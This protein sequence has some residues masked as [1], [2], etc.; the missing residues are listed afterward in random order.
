[1]AA[2]TCAAPPLHATPLQVCLISGAS[3]CKSD[4][5]LKLF[6]D[7][8]ESGFNAECTLLQTPDLNALPGLE[9]LDACDVALFF[10]QGI[11][12]DGEALGRVKRYCAAGKPI[13]GVRTA[14]RGFDKWPAFD[15]E[16]L[17]GHYDGHFEE[18]P[19]VEVSFK[20]PA[21]KHPIMEGVE[22]FRSR[23]SLYRTAPLAK[24]AQCLL[25]GHI[26][27]EHAPQPLAWT[28]ED[29]GCRVFYTSLG[30]VDDF[31][32]ASFK[33][34]IANA[35]FWTAKR[36]IERK[37]LPEIPPRPKNEGT[38][39][40]NARMRVEP[41]HG[42]GAWEEKTAE[43]ELPVGATAIVVCD[44]WDDYW[45]SFSRERVDKMAPA[46][47]ILIAAARKAGMPII[48]APSETLGFY[49]ETIPRR[50]AQAAP[51][52]RPPKPRQIEEP[53]LPVDDSD[54]GC[55]IRADKAYMAWT[56]EHAAVTIDDTDFVSDDGREIYNVLQ[57][58]GVKNLI[59]LG[60]H[61]NTCVL[62]RSFGIR[63]MTR[64]GVHCFL[65]R[66]LTDAMYNPARPPKVDHDKGSELVVEHI[67]KYWC[68]SILSEDL[69]KGLPKP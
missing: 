26:P 52:V 7:Y 3:E 23:S 17:G 25:L 39:R 45:C 10:T 56:R 44:L 47:D 22:L 30:S 40:V 18:G 60:V 51:H 31:E 53:A 65:V 50:R 35:L 9:S 49:T 55:P 66:D 48:H 13:V 38:I 58:E 34:M 57:Q 42:G 29:K 28:R 62:S 21:R 33:R 59:L 5:A 63:Q 12:I 4:I 32:G 24:D 1:M 2:L 43:R 67:E 14:S 27:S 8:L 15:K 68:P 36:D 11:K 16:I 37:P 41:S 19:T 69:L 54:G 20:A 46:V 64:W 6:K 61:S